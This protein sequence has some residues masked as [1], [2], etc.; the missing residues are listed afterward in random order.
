MEKNLQV[1]LLD[2]EPIVCKRLKPALEKDGFEVEI[3]NR[4]RDALDRINEKEFD[5]VVTDFRIDDIRIGEEV[6][7]ELEYYSKAMVKDADG[8]HQIGFNA[9]DVTMTDELLGDDAELAVVLGTVYDLFKVIG[10][11]TERDRTDSKGEFNDEV[12]QLIN[13]SGR[14]LRRSGK[15]L[16]F[17]PRGRRL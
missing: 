17:Q 8:D 10:G 1:L 13:R 2:D 7:M 4:S 16:N 9:D 3:F 14:P 6:E 12:I 5:V 11:K 15:V